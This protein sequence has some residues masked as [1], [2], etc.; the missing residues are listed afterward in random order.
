MVDES[1]VVMREGAE[2]GRGRVA[3]ES[4]AVV[5][6]EAARGEVEGDT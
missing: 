2:R 5:K 1:A 6:G 4:A 3:D